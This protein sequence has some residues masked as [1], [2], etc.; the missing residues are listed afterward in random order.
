MFGMSWGGKRTGAGR[1]TD[2]KGRQTF[3]FRLK[4]TVAEAFRD[5]C[6]TLSV[7]QSAVLEMLITEWIGVHQVEAEAAVKA[8]GPDKWPP[9]ARV[10]NLD[11]LNDIRFRRRAE[12]LVAQVFGIEGLNRFRA[13]KGST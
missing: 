6:F 3:S 8:L 13:Q 2:Q 10:K 9:P 4:P 7:P 11:R 1:P 5:Y 12:Q